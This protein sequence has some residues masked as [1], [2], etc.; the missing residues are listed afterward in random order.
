[1]TLSNGR[2][3]YDLDALDH[4]FSAGGHMLLLCNPHNPLG[5]V[6]EADEL[7]TISRVVAYHG[8]RVFADEIHAPLVYGSHRHVP[9]ASVSE[10]AAEQ[11]ITASSASKAWNLAGLKCAQVLLSNDA[12]RERWGR[13][14]R[15]ATDGTSTLGAVAAVAAFQ[16]GRPWL[17][18]VF[19]YLDRNRILLGQ[20]L[21]EHLPAARYT[22]PEGTFLAWLD[23]RELRGSARPADL[24]AEAA[25]VTVVD[26]ADCGIPGR[27]FVRL[28]FATTDELLCRMVRR[29]AH[30]LTGRSL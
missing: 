13:L 10:A 22:P 9:Y 16:H 24:I 4:A 5:R 2:Y 30:A 23:L 21:S 26:G 6:L 25:G 3:H 12:D 28:N 19:A 15:L 14:G 29:L 8:G 20:L 1:M 27:G 18:A 11:A 17:D 7:A